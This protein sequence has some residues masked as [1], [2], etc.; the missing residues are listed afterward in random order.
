MRKLLA[1]MF[2]ALLMVG[3]GQSEEAVQEEA[4]DWDDLATLD[5]IIAGAIDNE[6]IQSRGEEGEKLVYAPNQQTPYSGWAKRMYD[7]G[8]IEWLFQFSDGKWDG[9]ATAWYTNGQKKLEQIYKD[10]KLMTARSWKPNGEKC[11]ETNVVNGNGVRVWY[12]EDGTEE[13]RWTF[14]DGVKVED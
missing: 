1:A 6:K 14:K 10:G 4:I 11:P 9:P 13:A 5:K 7:N 8:Q 2:V 12:R 3:C